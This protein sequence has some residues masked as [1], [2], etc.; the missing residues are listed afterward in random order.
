[1]QVKHVDF[2]TRYF[3]KVHQLQQDEA[4]RA[5][6]LMRVDVVAQQQNNDG[7]WEPGELHANVTS[8]V[9]GSDIIITLLLLLLLLEWHRCVYV[10]TVT[11]E[12]LRVLILP[13][14][15]RHQ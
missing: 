5:Q 3:Y 12:I 13:L 15:L 1:M 14:A 7:D 11:G 8:V 4:R 2:W 10:Q 6:L 9:T